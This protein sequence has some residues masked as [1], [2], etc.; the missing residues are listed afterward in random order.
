MK[1]DVVDDH[2][3]NPHQ[4]SS[5]YSNLNFNIP[6]FMNHD[7]LQQPPKHTLEVAVLSAV[8]SK[9][10]RRGALRE[11]S[12]NEAANSGDVPWRNQRRDRL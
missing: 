4:N 6:G 3:S 7:V 10:P 9:L 2:Q 1:V 11:L 8:P 12:H 5:E